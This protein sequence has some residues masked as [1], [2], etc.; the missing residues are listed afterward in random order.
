[1][2]AGLF[3]TDSKGKTC[4]IGMARVAGDGDTN[5]LNDV[6]ILQEHQ[7]S[8]LGVTFLKLVLDG[9]GREDWRW[10]LYTSGRQDWYVG[11]FGFRIVGEGLRT[12]AFG[13]P[14]Y[15]LE[16]DGR[17]LQALKAIEAQSNV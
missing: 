14:V 1:M 5:M 9:Q 2:I 8:G 13:S 17:T 7:G 16:R 11:K 10:L 3:H 4:M 6:Y 12:R 15:I